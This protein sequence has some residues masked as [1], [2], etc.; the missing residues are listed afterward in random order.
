MHIEIDKKKWEK[1]RNHMP[2]SVKSIFW[3][4]DEK[5]DKF[6]YSGSIHV[7][8]EKILDPVLQEWLELL[9]TNKERCARIIEN[10]IKQWL[11]AKNGAAAGEKI[12][13]VRNAPSVGALFLVQNSPR[14]WIYTKEDG[15]T[16]AL[17]VDRLEY[18]EATKRQDYYHPEHVTLTV[19]YR[20]L[21]KFHKKSFSFYAEDCVGLTFAEMILTKNLLVETPELIQEYETQ[22]S[23]YF[24]YVDK[25]GLQMLAVGWCDNRGVKEDTDIQRNSYF[26][27]RDYFRIELDPN[28]VPARVVV[29][30]VENTDADTDSNR[31]SKERPSSSWWRLWENNLAHL[32][33]GEDFDNGDD[34]S[35]ILLD[36]EKPPFEAQ[37]PIWP[38][39]ICFDLKRHLRVSVHLSQLEEY[40]Y[41]PDAHKQLVLPPETT[42][43]I[44]ILL[45]DKTQFRDVI[46]NKAGGTIILCQGPPGVGKTLTAEINA[47][48]TRRP[49]YNVQCS[50]LGTDPN[51]LEENLMLILKRGR[52]WNAVTLLDESDV[53][54]CQRG[55]NLQQNAIVGVFL[56]VLEYQGNTLFLTTNRADL[57]DDAILSRCTARLCYKVP[58][59][60]DQKSIWEILTVINGIDLAPKQISALAE[61]NPNLSGRDVKNIL[62][63][64]VMVAKAK[65]QRFEDDPLPIVKYVRQFKPTTDNTNV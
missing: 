56:R 44:N 57:V 8:L 50:Q 1:L 46:Q 14:R 53:Y 51:E 34:E 47:E 31:S 60:E 3:D 18:R 2:E 25:I 37:A 21:G 19:T 54:V 35:E 40:I 42:D 43:I 6:L 33:L 15:Q 23:R 9:K 41:D 36:N 48:V 7:H 62:K 4:R 24:Q 27:H 22:T 38:Y 10:D 59:M 5:K 30:S 45:H 58:T 61:A 63:L 17:Y 13:R 64:G 20:Y 29:D 39:I 49:L 65:N 32:D 55:T 12:R 28:N 16:V 11:A 52:R 26:S